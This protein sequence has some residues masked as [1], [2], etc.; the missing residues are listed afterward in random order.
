MKVSMDMIDRQ[1]RRNGRFMKVFL[2]YKD[3]KALVTMGRF[4]QKVL[5]NKKSLKLN[6]DVYFIEREDSRKIRLC[7]Y[8]P[9][10]KTGG[11]KLPGILWLHGGGYALGSATMAIPYAER[12]ILASEGIVVSPDYTLSGEKPYPAALEDCYAAL[13]WMKEHADDLG[14]YNNQFFVGGDSAGGGLAVAVSL[15]ARDKGEV[16]IAFQMPLYPMLDDRMTSGSMINN[17]APMWNEHANRLAW[18]LYLDNMYGKDDVS[19]YA[20]PAREM[21]YKNLPPAFSV[22]GSL[23]PFHDE[24]V[25]Y[26]ENLRAAGIEVEFYEYEGCFHAFD[27][28]NAKADRSQDALTK[29]AAAYKK[30]VLSIFK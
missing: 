25:C 30:A 17:D 14:I 1:Y 8:S 7:V 10:K 26:M 29:L 9:K 28:A 24:T 18:R 5:G 22:V 12:L 11:G 23:D 21:N 4:S 13:L 16:G 27:E 6:N 19:V 3:E 2:R 20:A 15:Y